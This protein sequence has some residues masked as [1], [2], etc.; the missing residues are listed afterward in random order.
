MKNA[1]NKY[2]I[3]NNLETK[4]GQPALRAI[5]RYLRGLGVG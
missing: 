1:F 4:F 3:A 5:G 2:M